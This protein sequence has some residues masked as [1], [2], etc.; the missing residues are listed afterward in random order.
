ME[1]KENQ[2]FSIITAVKERKEY[3]NYYSNFTHDPKQ[4]KVEIHSLIDSGQHMWIERCQITPRRQVL[5]YGMWIGDVKSI[6][7]QCRDLYNKMRFISN[8]FFWIQHVSPDAMDWWSDI[9]L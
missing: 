8:M 1:S 9:Q 7:V 3:K 4:F 5:N 6:I 2:I